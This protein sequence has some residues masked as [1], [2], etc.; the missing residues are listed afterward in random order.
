MLGLQVQSFV[1]VEYFPHKG[2]S[3][4]Y[5]ELSVNWTKE[6]TLLSSFSNHAG[7]AD[8][9]YPKLYRVVFKHKIS[10]K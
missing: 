8:D 9:L 2:D 7:K 3:R 1:S 5:I 10:C 4:V 6:Y